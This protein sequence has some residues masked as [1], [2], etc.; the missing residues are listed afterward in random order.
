MR[1]KELLDPSSSEALGV[2]SCKKRTGT[3]PRRRTLVEFSTF[4][5]G[6]EY[7]KQN[8]SQ[9]MSENCLRVD[10]ILIISY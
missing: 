5:P 4:V 10:S 2:R 1:G 3:R 7:K 6:G 8:S 9:Y